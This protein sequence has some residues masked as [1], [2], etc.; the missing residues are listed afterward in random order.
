MQD[1]KATASGQLQFESNNEHDGDVE[2]ISDGE[3]TSSSEHGMFYPASITPGTPTEFKVNAMNEDELRKSVRRQK[4]ERL[5]LQLPSSGSPS[6]ASGGGTLSALSSA[7]GG[8]GTGTGTGTSDD[9]D[10]GSTPSG[11]NA[12]R[13]LAST[14]GGSAESIPAALAATATASAASS[15]F[16]QAAIDGPSSL[17]DRGDRSEWILS[18]QIG[19][20]HNEIVLS[21]TGRRSISAK[22]NSSDSKSFSKSFSNTKKE[23]LMKVINEAKQK[24]ENV[25][26]VSHHC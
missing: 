24:L 17:S 16:L 20:D 15:N 5:G 25:S 19:I 3:R 26:I 13:S 23:E 9:E 1:K 10:E 11:D 12:E 14:L 4:F 6:A 22:H 21:F 8:T 2:D 7:S 18:G